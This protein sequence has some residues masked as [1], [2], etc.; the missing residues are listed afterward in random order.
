M[1][2]GVTSFPKAASCSQLRGSGRPGRQRRLHP[3]RCCQALARSIPLEPG[4]SLWSIPLE[5]P[6]GASLWSP[7]CSREGTPTAPGYHPHHRKTLRF[8]LTEPLQPPLLLL[9]APSPRGCSQFPP[10]ISTATSEAGTGIYSQHLP[11]PP[12][13]LQTTHI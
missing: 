1:E 4:A 6:S 10:F 11:P 7:G 9:L 5:H 13:L 3:P 2:A 8:G 12:A